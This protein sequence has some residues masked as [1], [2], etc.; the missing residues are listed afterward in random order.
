MRVV[1]NDAI[2]ATQNKETAAAEGISAMPT[3]KAYRNRKEVASVQ[4][5]D[6]DAL[7]AM[8]KEHQGDK[9]SMAGAGHT[10]GSSSGAGGAAATGETE[11][12]PAAAAPTSLSEREKRLAALAKRGL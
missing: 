5:A 1:A 11:A 8:V 9:W 6:I 2:R 4:G 3:F 7:R 10:L 12:A